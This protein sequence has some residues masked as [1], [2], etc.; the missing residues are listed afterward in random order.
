MKKR[1]MAKKG[2]VLAADIGGTN[3]RCGVVSR[4]GKVLQLFETSSRPGETHRGMV[5]LLAATFERA[6]AAARLRDWKGLPVSIAVA[7]GVDAHRGVITQCPQFPKW[8][9]FALALALS[10]W[11][12]GEVF[13]RNDVDCALLGE[14]WK[15]AAKGRRTAA[16]IWMGTGV[17]GALVLDGKLFHGPSGMAGEFGHMVADPNGIP[18]HCGAAGCLETIASGW[19]VE[20]MARDLA[21]AGHPV[22]HPSGREDLTAH[23]VYEAARQKDPVA[24]DIW[25]RVGRALGE[26]VG[27]L[28]NALSIDFFVLGG[29][30]SAARR[31]FLPE[32]ERVAKARA[33]RYPGSRLRIRPAT[34]GDEA[35]LLGAAAVFFGLGE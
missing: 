19:A 9:N 29:K 8:K 12:G 7:G 18:C 30:V 15:G 34:L 26:S 28:V 10:K 2:L 33:F 6:L 24:L 27:S 16:A 25:A 17:G 21:R 14:C 13:V 4:T 11:S 5:E 35:A 1:A 31:F 3:L 32:L 23:D 20:Q 22:R